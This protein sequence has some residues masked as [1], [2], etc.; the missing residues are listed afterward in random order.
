MDPSPSDSPETISPNPGYSPTPPQ[1]GQTQKPTGRPRGQD[2][3]EDES[4]PRLRIWS[5]GAHLTDPELRT[6]ARDIPHY[7]RPR[8]SDGKISLKSSAAGA[9]SHSHSHSQ[10]PGLGLGDLES[11]AGG[12]SRTT[13]SAS[14]RS[15]S[16]T[17]AGD[18]GRGVAN[19]PT[20]RARRGLR[21]RDRGYKGSILER[22][23]AWLRSIFRA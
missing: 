20:G 5:L 14:F 16:R 7:V 19:L 6:L 22:L 10:N 1:G 9:N 15:R 8:G 11:G 4:F 23:S 2:P 17:D 21:P 3:T 18:G 12:F 13:S